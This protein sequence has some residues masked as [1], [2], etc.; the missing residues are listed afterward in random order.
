MSKKDSMRVNEAIRAPHVRVILSDGE[1]GGIM[2][3]RDALAQAKDEGLDLVEISPSADPPV[4]KIMNYGKYKFQQSKK[5]KDARTKQKQIQV[6]EIKFKP[7]IDEHD[8]QFK[9]KHIKRFIG[10]GDKVRTFVQ[11]RGREMTHREI[12]MRILQRVIVDTKDVAV[13]EKKP[14]MEGNHMAMYLVSVD[15]AAK[16]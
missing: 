16:K 7:R 10:Q 15:H 11:F 8:Y 3:S 14:D 2:A 5:L 9:L 13:V 12:G 4:C 1:Q 6:K